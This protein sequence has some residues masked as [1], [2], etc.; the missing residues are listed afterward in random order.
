MTAASRDLIFAPTPFL[1]GAGAIALVFR[2][3]S[4]KPAGRPEGFPAWCA[5][6][7]ADLELVGLVRQGNQAAFGELVARHKSRVFAMAARYTRNHHELDDLAQEVFIRA[8]QKFS[9]FRGDAPFEHWLMRL[10]VRCCFDFLRKHRSRREKEVSLE[11]LGSD[12]MPGED[13]IEPAAGP[14]ESVLKLRRALSQLAPKEQLVLTLL[15][16]EDRPVREVA[17]LTGWSEGNVKVRAH[18]ARLRLKQ[19]LSLS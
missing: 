6:V 1:E 17:S 19:L 14:A 4:A 8:W 15:E 13:C 12:A 7:D 16:L 9:K 5:P 2:S 3:R 10:A 18:R 11:A